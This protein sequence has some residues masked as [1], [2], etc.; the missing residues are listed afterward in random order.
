VVLL[1]ALQRRRPASF[2]LLPRRR[3]VGGILATLFLPL[4][5]AHLHSPLYV[6]SKNSP[7]GRSHP[8]TPR[9]VRYHLHA[10]L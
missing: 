8:A 4:F 9:A 10:G 5:L 6:L 7:A 3:P 2:T 1:Q